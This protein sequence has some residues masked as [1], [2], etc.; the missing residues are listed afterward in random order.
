MIL[1]TKIIHQADVES[2]WKVLTSTPRVA[3]AVRTRVQGSASAEKI[4]PAVFST[5]GISDVL[6][7][8]R[9]LTPFEL[10]HTM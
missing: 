5:A 2:R 4:A 6:S 10:P 3:R 7:W 9:P 8:S 1:S